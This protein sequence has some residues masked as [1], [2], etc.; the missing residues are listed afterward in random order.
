MKDF[1]AERPRKGSK[2]DQ[3][4]QNAGFTGL[5]VD[6]GDPDVA[7]LKN[8][9]AGNLAPMGITSV[10]FVEPEQLSI[11]V[12]HRGEPQVARSH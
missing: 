4:D 11:P 12:D 8:S 9:I 3:A 5:G 2:P 6:D 1:T 7:A 10:T